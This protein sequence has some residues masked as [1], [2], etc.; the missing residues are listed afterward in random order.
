VGMHFGVVAATA[1]WDRFFGELST[2]TG[3]FLDRG[4][5]TDLHEV[6]FDHMGDDGFG[7]IGGDLAGQAYL[8]DNS[9]VLSGSGYDRLVELSGRLQCTVAAC[10]AETVSGT[11]GLLIARTGGLECLFFNCVSSIREP[12]LMGR[13]LTVDDLACL[14]DIDG[15]GLFAA[16][17]LQGL[18]Y[19]AWSDTGSK[20]LYL[21]TWDELFQDPPPAKGPIEAAVDEHSR[22]H[23]Y[24]KEQV[25]KPKVVAR[26]LPD[27]STGYDIVAQRPGD[28]LK[29]WLGRLRGK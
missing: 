13:G 6:D 15:G 11:F 1:P 25:L 16:L 8:Y 19:L 20:H 9:M 2:L 23:A 7:V 5:V 10:L 29:G 26:K 3:R 22:L 12:F 28:K 18:D 4:E 17:R 27:G 21:Y 24:P 14:Q